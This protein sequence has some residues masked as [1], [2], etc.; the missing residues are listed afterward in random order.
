M[1]QT[2]PTDPRRDTA[3]QVE[4]LWNLGWSVRRIAKALDISTQ[5]VYQIRDARG[6]KERA[7]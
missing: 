4:K 7:S 2:T 6:L 3:D 5:R 1:E